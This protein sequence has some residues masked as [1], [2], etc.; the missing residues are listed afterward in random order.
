MGYGDGKAKRTGNSAKNIADCFLS[1]NGFQV[2]NSPRDEKG[3]DRNIMLP[4]KSGK[5][6]K[7]R[8]RGRSGINNPDTPRWFQFKISASDIAESVKKGKDLEHLWQDAI[9]KADFWILV[10]LQ[11]QGNEV[12]VFPTEVILEIA[13]LNAPHYQEWTSN[14]F[15]KPAYKQKG[16]NPGEMA[17][18]QKEL[19]LHV[20]DKSGVI[21]ENRF[22]SYKNNADVLHAYFQ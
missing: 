1:D 13:R 17:G 12:W 8:I 9:K 2:L 19:N 16:N 10:S 11:E 14:D 15:S 4:G 21:L 3:V 7:V 18:K 6:A 22:Q 20:T 5:E